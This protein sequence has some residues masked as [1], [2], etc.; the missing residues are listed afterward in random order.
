M[1][2]LLVITFI[3]LF[4]QLQAQ[5]QI[6]EKEAFLTAERFLQENTKLQQPT[7]ALTEVINSKQSGHANLYV[8]SVEPRGFVIVSALNDVLAYSLTSSMLKSEVLP[9]HISYWLNLY[10]EA[11]DNLFEHPE[12][13]KESTRSQTTV[14]PLLT[15]CWGQGC[16]HNEACPADEHGPCQ[17]VSAGC[18]AIAMAQIMYFHKQP[19]VG[20]GSVTYSCS[21]YGTLSANFGQTTYHWENMADTLHEN[22]A[23]VAQLVSHCGIAVNMQYGAHVSLAN[24]AKAL[25]ALRQNFFYPSANL[26]QRDNY[27]DEEWMNLIVSDLDNGHPVYYAGVSD[28]GGHAFVCDGYDDNG[29]FHFNF[30]WDG[31]A[32][33]YYTLNAP[34]GFSERQA[35]ICNIYSANDIPINSD[36]HGIIHVAQ[37]GSGDGS[38]WENATPELQLAI[39]KSLTDNTSVWVKEGTY[40]GETFEDYAFRLLDK[41]SMYGGFKGD[42]PF[43]YDLSLRDFEAHPTILDGNHAQGVVKVL[44][45]IDNG[46]ILVDGFTIQNGNTSQ[47]GGIFIDGNTMVRNCK[48]GHNDADNGGG[49]IQRTKSPNTVVIEH[50]EIFNNSATTGGGVYDFGSSTYQHCQMHDNTAQQKGGGLMCS[51]LNN[52]AQSTFVGCTVCNN[53]A[54]SGGGLYSSTSKATF[55]SCV[56]SNNTAQTGGGCELAKNAKLYNCTIV[57]NEAEIDYGGVYNYQPESQDFIMNCII[58]GNVSQGE[59]AQIAPTDFYSF[60]AVED[61]ASVIESNFKAESE[62]DGNSTGFYVRFKDSDVIAGSTGNGGDWR[63]QPNSLCIDRGENISG[64]PASD[65]DGNNRFMH[66]SVDIGAYESNTVAHFIEA[67]FCELDPYYYQDSLIPSI[68]YYSFLYPDNAYDSLVILHM[69]NPPPTVF[70]KEE[71]CENETFDFFGTLLS[72]SGVYYEAIDCITHK[73]ELSIIPLDI[74][75]MQKEICENETFNFFGIQLNEAGTYYDTI[76]CTAYRLEL[77]V[78]PLANYYLEESICEGET[79]DFF[80]RSLQQEGHYFKTMD[81]RYYELDLNINPKPMLRYSGDTIVKYGNPVFLFASGADSYLWS[82]GDTTDRI[83][84]FPTENRIYSVTGFSKSGCRSMANINVTIDLSEDEIVIFPNPA[85]DKVEIYAPLIDE[86]EVFNLYGFRIEQIQAE[87]EAVTLDIS[88]YFNGVYIIHVRQL[89]N[90]D[91]KKLIIRH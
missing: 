47:G 61:D 13:R 14:E 42:E 60:C 88:R 76:G 82:T 25:A 67:V 29:M 71:I 37:D 4:A 65:L 73:L 64:Q 83:T 38:S 26:L 57:K 89:N 74:V 23:A 21:P 48:I 91:Y 1:K 24:N 19:L 55:W 15:S 30:G 12:Q 72:E 80:G 7:I 6:G 2:R 17:H 78:K 28:L 68:G 70:H 54:Q 40:Y 8:F 3:L 32:D 20:N 44:V 63:L 87:R 53:T 49:I 10:N 34:Y 5:V 18:V 16:Y 77:G 9:D 69:I 75:N 35:A 85:D 43:D 59:N 22:N 41:C 36:E 79:Y 90:H 84:V 11:T 56:F 50:C 86:V 45:N 66:R 51:N 27:D 31:V 39:Y 81:C 62:N 58:W 46:F 33:G 52:N